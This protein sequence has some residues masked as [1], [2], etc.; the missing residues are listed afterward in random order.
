MQG[1]E[2]APW[3]PGAAALAGEGPPAVNPVVFTGRGPHGSYIWES[4]CEYTLRTPCGGIEYVGGADQCG[5][6]AY[7]KKTWAPEEFYEGVNQIFVKG[8]VFAMDSW[9]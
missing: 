9:D 2:I 4:N 3:L 8:T 7:F 6:G 1:P 5:W